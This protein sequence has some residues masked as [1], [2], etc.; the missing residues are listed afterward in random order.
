MSCNCTNMIVLSFMIS[1][2][3][4]SFEIRKW[5]IPAV[6]QL[7]NFHAMK[8]QWSDTSCTID[9]HSL[10]STDNAALRSGEK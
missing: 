2:S 7:T 3:F 1:T 10:T 4:A 6:Y 5:Y 8:R 9:S